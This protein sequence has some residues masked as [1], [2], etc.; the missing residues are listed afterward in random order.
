[1]VKSALQTAHDL[2]HMALLLRIVFLPIVLSKLQSGLPA[3]PGSRSKTAPN[4]YT[5]LDA[6]VA[7]G[8]PNSCHFIVKR[9]FANFRGPAAW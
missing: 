6:P 2:I 9:L 3:S 4:S 5:W 1:L 8:M 7:F